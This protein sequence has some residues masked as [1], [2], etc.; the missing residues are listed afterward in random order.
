MLYIG[1]PLVLGASLLIGTIIK[2]GIF[3]VLPLVVTPGS[4]A[5]MMHL[6]WALLL[7]VNVLFHYAMGVTTNPGSHGSDVYQKLCEEAKSRGL[8][9]NLKPIILPRPGEWS[10]CTKTGLP[11]PPRSHFDKVTKRLVIQMDHYCPWLFNTVGWANLRY[12][13]FFQVYLVISTLYITFMTF[14]PFVSVVGAPTGHENDEKVWTLPNN[15]TVLK[16]ARDRIIFLFAV[17]SPVSTFLFLFLMWN[18]YL[19]LTAQ[20]SV[21]VQI[22]KLFQKEAVAQGLVFTNPYDL[23]YRE[24]WYQAMGRVS[25]IWHVIPSRHM[26]PWPPYPTMKGPYSCLHRKKPAKSDKANNHKDQKKMG[27]A[28]WVMNLVTYEKS[29]LASSQ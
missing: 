4:F 18:L 11:K 9:K 13:M 27:H 8:L 10:K 15:S 16:P 28:E 23:G 26:P 6:L 25:P 2:F 3:D 21:E 7:S 24:N 20:T 19:V 12:Y 22:N 5:H 14:W 29:S 17:S 1:P